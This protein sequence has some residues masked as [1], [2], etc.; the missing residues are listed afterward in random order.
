MEG[1]TGYITLAHMDDEGV[2]ADPKS[3][4]CR[5]YGAVLCN[6][7]TIKGAHLV[8]PRM[9]RWWS[10]QSI[11]KCW[12]VSSCWPIPFIRLM[13]RLLADSWAR[14]TAQRLTAEFLCSLT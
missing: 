7:C 4:A 10:A 11:N 12:T 5:A 8:Q 6:R 3:G 2:V 1:C 9:D 14:S 13:A